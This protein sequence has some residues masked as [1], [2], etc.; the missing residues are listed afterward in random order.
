MQSLQIDVQPCTADKCLIEQLLPLCVPVIFQT[1]L[2]CSSEPASA[3]STA[4]CRAASLPLPLPLSLLL[5][6]RNSAAAV[7]V[8]S[9]LMI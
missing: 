3:Q 1:H 4:S 6:L 2:T 7:I 8:M 9:G 5:L